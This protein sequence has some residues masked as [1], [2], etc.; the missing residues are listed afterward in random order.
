MCNIT[1]R[2]SRDDSR[3]MEGLTKMSDICRVL[4]DKS[5]TFPVLTKACRCHITLLSQLHTPRW[6]NTEQHVPLGTLTVC[7]SRRAFTAEGQ[8]VQKIQH[9]KVCSHHEFKHL[10]VTLTLQCSS[11][12]IPSGHDAQHTIFSR[13]KYSNLW[14]S[15]THYGRKTMRTKIWNRVDCQHSEK[16]PKQE[17][18]ERESF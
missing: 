2:L 11:L 18:D 9:A 8:V 4:F 10:H 12:H 5:L 14:N 15:I 1:H 17:R 3:P 6:N 16:D 7:L 13:K